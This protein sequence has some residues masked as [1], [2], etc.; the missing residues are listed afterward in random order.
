[1]DCIRIRSSWMWTYLFLWH[2]QNTKSALCKVNDSRPCLLLASIDSSLLR[3]RPSLWNPNQSR[4][5]EAIAEGL[6]RLVHTCHSWSQEFV[7]WT[8]FS[9]FRTIDSERSPSKVQN[10]CKWKRDR[11]ESVW[12]SF[13]CSQYRLRVFTRFWLGASPLCKIIPCHFRFL[14]QLST[15]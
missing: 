6:T 15:F 5:G 4:L 14:T 7:W 3:F 8:L 9:R 12:L 13:C 10:S 2:Y 1:M 11:I